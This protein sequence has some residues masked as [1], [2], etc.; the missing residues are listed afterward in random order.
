MAHGY[1]AE[2]GGFESSEHPRY[3]RLATASVGPAHTARHDQLRD[4]VRA[5]IQHELQQAQIRAA[6]KARAALNFVIAPPGFGKTTLLRHLLESQAADCHCLWIT[7]SFCEHDEAQ[8]AREM[9]EHPNVAMFCD[10]A[11]KLGLERIEQL[12]RTIAMRGD[13]GHR[14]FIASTQPLHLECTALALAHEQAVL[15]ASD[16]AVEFGYGDRGNLPRSQ[17][18]LLDQIREHTGTWPVALAMV[19]AQLEIAVTEEG[20][21]Q[22]ESTATSWAE[23]VAERVFR[24]L[25]ERQRRHLSLLAGLACDTLMPAGDAECEAALSSL[26]ELSW[27]VPLVRI[28]MGRRVVLEWNP[29]LRRAAAEL[30]RPADHATSLRMNHALV[31]PLALAGCFDAAIQ[32]ASRSGNSATLAAVLEEAGGWRLALHNGIKYMHLFDLYAPAQAEPPLLVRLGQI[33]ALLRSGCVAEGMAAYEDFRR[34]HVPNGDLELAPER[35]RIDLAVLDVFVDLHRDSE[36]YPL[37]AALLERELPVIMARMR[38]LAGAAFCTICAH[39]FTAFDFQRTGHFIDAGLSYSDHPELEYVRVLLST[40]GIIT[41]CLLGDLRAAGEALARWHAHSSSLDFGQE[42][43]VR[44]IDIA[45]AYSHYHAGQ[46]EAAYELI[47]GWEHVLVGHEVWTELHL[48]CAEAIAKTLLRSEGREAAAAAVARL[49]AAGAGQGIFFVSYL[50]WLRAEIDSITGVQ[51]T[52]SASLPV[53]TEARMGERKWRALGAKYAM[54]RIRLLIRRGDES[55]PAALANTAA[56]VAPTG[57][58]IAATRIEILAII[59]AART[60]REAVHERFSAL[61][62]RTDR[63]LVRTVLEEEKFGFAAVAGDLLVALDSVSNAS[64]AYLTTGVSPLAQETESVPRAPLSPREREILALIGEGL[65]TKEI[66]NR[67]DISVGTVKTFRI[68]LYRKLNV[69]R[70]SGAVALARLFGRH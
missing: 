20:I 60:D 65:S 57:D 32:C 8:L 24:R 17:R 25:C 6:R 54:L 11:E 48:H 51:T 56:A 22:P 30:L 49:A 68:R 70:R 43:W 23:Y 63:E 31:R 46:L 14:M 29:V 27:L 47:E 34:R 4:P 64:S 40:Y 52:Q 26:H 53:A 7:P 19:Q 58:I 36:C 35:I 33:Y 61:L 1:S 12:W 9:G 38:P 44:L 2:A 69:S 13:Q 28:R 16:L 3:L 15:R 10:D 55:S 59:D 45:A 18:R 21:F 62:A 39:A 37:S 42:P 67:L 66:A 5:L 41:Y 50:H